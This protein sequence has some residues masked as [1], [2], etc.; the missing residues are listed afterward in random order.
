MTPWIVEY[1]ASLSFLW[2]FKASYYL[3]VIQRPNEELITNAAACQELVIWIERYTEHRAVMSLQS[4]QTLSILDVPDLNR[5]VSTCAG[6]YRDWVRCKEISC[7]RA[8]V[9]EW[10]IIPFDAINW[11]MMTF[12]SLHR[13]VLLWGPQIND[14]IFRA[15]RKQ[16][17]CRIPFNDIQVSLV[18][19][20]HPQRLILSQTPKIYVLIERA[21]GKISLILPI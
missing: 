9:L 5:I 15:A 2:H 6:Y 17:T 12:E 11:G 14:L 7:T 3:L 20:P 8:V 16:G 19:S 21:W 18:P 13:L 1:H 10:M 4:H